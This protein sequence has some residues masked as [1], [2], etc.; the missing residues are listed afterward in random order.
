MYTWSVVMMIL[1]PPHTTSSRT[2]CS[3]SSFP[4]EEP[5]DD[6]AKLSDVR[7]SSDVTRPRLLGNVYREMDVMSPTRQPINLVEIRHF[8]RRVSVSESQGSEGTPYGV[9][10]RSQ[11]ETRDWVRS[12]TQGRGTGELTVSRSQSLEVHRSSCESKSSTSDPGI[13]LQSPTR[14]INQIRESAE[15]LD[16]RFRAISSSDKVRADPELEPKLEVFKVDLEGFKA[17]LD[18]VTDRVSSPVDLEAGL[19]N[20]SPTDRLTD[21]PTYRPIDVTIDRPT[22]IPT[23]RPTDTSKDVPTD[24][25]VDRPT[26]KFGA[27]KN[28]EA[29]RFEGKSYGDEIQKPLDSYAPTDAQLLP[30]RRPGLDEAKISER[31]KS[32]GMRFTSPGISYG[33]FL[34]A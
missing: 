10:S 7:N 5:R 6:V 3:G 23:D 20:I 32:T 21:R 24:R 13:P 22:Y 12:R 25:Q 28:P 29:F 11:E 4:E 19:S 34:L 33:L 18:R 8:S 15:K 27:M 31:R 14:V 16:S 9:R 30:P 1:D 2:D 17:D 26:G